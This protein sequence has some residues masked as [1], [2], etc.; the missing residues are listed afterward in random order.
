MLCKS[1]HTDKLKCILKYAVL[2]SVLWSV[3]LVCVSCAHVRKTFSLQ[4]LLCYS[5]AC[6]SYIVLYAWT[7][8]ELALCV[9]FRLC[10]PEREVPLAQLLIVLVCLLRAALCS[11]ETHVFVL[12]HILCHS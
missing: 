10:E 6:N 12:L 8:S 1:F 4:W 11:T 9:N 3:F 5:V 2:D 7:D